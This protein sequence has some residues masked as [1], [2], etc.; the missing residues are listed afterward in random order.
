[1]AS[2]LTCYF[3]LNA[4]YRTVLCG[5]PDPYY[6]QL[7]EGLKAYCLIQMS[8]IP[9]TFGLGFYVS[10]IVKRWW[11]QYRLLPWPDSLAIFV[12]GLL[13][14]QVGRAAGDWQSW[15]FFAAKLR[16]RRC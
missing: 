14:G 11:D 13:R 1:M 2:Y 4:F 10:L 16:P 15:F 6:R 12:V 9:M 7:F 8:S 5:M 3:L